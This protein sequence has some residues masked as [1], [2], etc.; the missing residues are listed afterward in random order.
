MK[1]QIITAD[2]PWS[3]NARVC[4]KERADGTKKPRFGEGAM[5]HYGT[6]DNSDIIAMG[7]LVEA[8]AEKNSLLF[9]WATMPL[10]DVAIEVV[11]GWGFRYATCAFVWIKT[12]KKAREYVGRCNWNGEP[13]DYSALLEMI[14]T[15]S[16]GYYTASNAEI[17]LL[18][19][20]GSMEP[21]VRLINSV[22]FGL[23][24]AHSKKPE[25]VQDRIDRM[26]P[27]RSK[28]EL[29]ARRTRENWTCVGNEISYGRD[30][31]SSLEV[32]AEFNPYK[33]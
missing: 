24:E 4:H 9:L 13:V 31:R 25:T 19:A 29:F 3:Y 1:W 27:G 22:V 11:K 20:R 26:Y 6:M 17:V 8:V 15:T 18:G 10:L 2:P 32:L 30:I 16:P 7:S 14:P 28:L 33:R 12:T 23:R 5:G 21:D